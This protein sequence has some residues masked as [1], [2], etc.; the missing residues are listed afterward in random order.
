MK[1]LITKKNFELGFFLGVVSIFSQTILIR[2]LF[3]V[4]GFTE[5]LLV[6]LLFLWLIWGALGSLLRRNINTT[7]ALSIF[8]ILSSFIPVF[9]KIIAIPLR[10]FFGLVVPIWRLSIA[11]AICSFPCFFGGMTFAALSS[12]SD[13]DKIYASEGLGAFFG[14]ILTILTLKIIPQLWIFAILAMILA[15]LFAVYK[16]RKNA[17]FTLSVICIAALSNLIT[18]QINSA[19]W[20]GFHVSEIESN[21]G[22]INVLRREDE[23]TIY[24]NGRLITSSGDTLMM[25]QIIHPI[26]WAHKNPEKILLIGGIYK[27]GIKDLIKHNPQKIVAPYSDR[28][29]MR[30]AIASI[31][32]VRHSIKDKKLELINIDPVILP[33]KMQDKFDVVIVSPGLP[34]MGAD[35]RFWTLEFFNSL[36]NLV[37]SEGIIGVALP[38]GM[39]FLSE[40]QKELVSSIWFTFKYVYSDAEIYFPEGNIL[41]IANPNRKVNF[42]SRLASDSLTPIETATIPME[43]LPIMFQIER[44]ITLKQQ[45]ASAKFTRLNKNWRPLAYLWGILEHAYLGE[46]PISTKWLSKE[47]VRNVTVILIVLFLIILGLGKLICK[48]SNAIIWPF[49]GGVWG[50]SNQT[51]FL[52]VL[53]ANYGS[54]YWL[55]GLA[56]GL[57]LFGSALGS[58]FGGRNLKNV[59]LAVLSLSVMILIATTSLGMHFG[60]MTLVI[61]YI[62]FLIS[63]S[64]TGLCF[65]A[66]SRIINRG[67]ILYAADL[68]GASVGA[69]VSIYLIPTVS[70]LVIVCGLGGFAVLAGILSKNRL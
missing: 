28:V 14:G 62:V 49:F 13:A 38:V 58:Y 51:L 34:S 22:R 53:Q 35:N 25:E 54:L 8:I 16:E 2:E 21:Y 63:G 19:L 64:I 15:A 43:Y 12:D 11:G 3:A 20:K 10:P 45:L 30:T 69:I 6:I 5:L 44:S 70:P 4:Y 9:V 66:A 57:F 48:T 17:I 7:R 27:G 50:I 46:T 56:N 67:K 36:K 41:L 32:S 39:N 37:E 47:T 18:P 24:E 65:G 29:L 26:V 42:L 60:R 1:G 52:L 23:S 31:P 55:L 68:L 40:Y 59:T 33:F 61:Y